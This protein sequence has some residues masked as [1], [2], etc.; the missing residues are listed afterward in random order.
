MEVMF[1]LMRYVGINHRP[2]TGVKLKLKELGSF[3]I[4]VNRV[5]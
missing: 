3:N 1:K 5:L 4:G 2:S